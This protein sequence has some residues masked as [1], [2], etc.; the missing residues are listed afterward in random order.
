[1]T[2][3]LKV[4]LG[5]LV[6]IKHGYA[7]K[8]EYFRDAPPGDVLL[9]PGNFAIGGGFQL[10]K[11]KYYDGPVVA[12]FVLSPGDLLVTMT[13]LSKAG[14]TLGYPAIVPADRHYLHNQRLGKVLIVD[15]KVSQGFIY[16][17]MRTKPYRDEVLSGVTG[18]TV[19]HTSPKKIEA[20]EF[21]LPSRPEQDAICEVLFALEDK[22]ELN[23]RM[24]ETLE[25]MAQ[26]IF[27]DWFVDFGPVRRK[28]AGV[29]APVEIMGGVTTDPDQASI[30]A[31]H[32]PGT[33]CDDGLPSGWSLESLGNLAEQI[34]M[35][36]FGSN[37]K[38]ET[39]V[40]QGIPVVSGSH[41]RGLRL[42][43]HSFNFLSIDHADKLARS[44]VRRG[45]IVFTHAGN[46]GQVSIIPE[47][48]QYE[49]YVLSQRQFYMR[50]NQDLISPFYVLH[51]FH[52]P[53]GQHALLANASQVGVPS[54]ARPATYLRS[55]EVCRPPRG[56]LSEFDKIVGALHLKAG[57]NLIE[58]RTLAEARDYLLP[59][60]M[61][62]EVRVGDAA[63]EIAA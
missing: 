57:S 8:G 42:H 7:F 58:S 55:I 22:I 23:R 40:E 10:G 2:D 34:A 13:D 1:M 59:R 15:A 44:N 36:P 37:I 41:L 54:I 61:S 48:S 5:E 24:N 45:D 14:D 16:W 12:G 6:S 33:L 11:V 47:T 56:V 38:V 49:R 39:F 3:W 63:K 31:S 19:K 52:S 32:F 50:C 26:A 46:I 17:L 18:S 60:L 21:Q 27:R 20:F 29:T 9:T 62:G 51:F 35:G 53:V 30:L 25:A 4:K 43:D 28:L